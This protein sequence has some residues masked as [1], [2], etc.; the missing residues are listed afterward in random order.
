MHA[1]SS[2][3]QRGSRGGQP[4]GCQIEFDGANAFA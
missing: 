2:A 1:V 4:L 3:C